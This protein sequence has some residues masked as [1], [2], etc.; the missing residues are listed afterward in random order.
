MS[1]L[2]CAIRVNPE[3]PIYLP[4]LMGFFH[5]NHLSMLALASPRE[6]PMNYKAIKQSQ[7]GFFSL[8]LAKWLF[9][10]ASDNMTPLKLTK[11]SD[12]ISV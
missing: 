1:Y 10:N 6:E 5:E 12:H 7:V 3:L 2:L 4:A 8:L 11:S 9:C